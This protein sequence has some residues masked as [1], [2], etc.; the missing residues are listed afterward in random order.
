MIARHANG[1]GLR[2]ALPLALLACAAV[3]GAE[4]LDA[5]EEPQAKPVAPAFKIEMGRSGPVVGIKKTD[6]AK[7]GDLFEVHRGGACIGY[8]EVHDMEG[9]WPRLRCLVGA[10]AKGDGLVP[11]GARIPRVFLA[12]DKPKAP[13][14]AELRALAGPD[15][16]RVSDYTADRFEV[17]RPTDL[18]VGLLHEGA[19]FV[20]GDPVVQPHLNA[21]GAAVVDTRLYVFLKQIKFDDSYLK[22]K[23]ELMI[24]QEGGLTAGL[25]ERDTLPWYGPPVDREVTV[26]LR[27]RK[28]RKIVVRKVKRKVKRYRAR[29]FRRPPL[30]EDP[31]RV[32]A[33]TPDGTHIAVFED[34]DAGRLLVCDFLT[35]SGRA[36]RDPGSKNKL[37]FLTRMLG[38]G[39]RYARYRPE[40]PPRADFYDELTDLREDNRGIV[41]LIGEGDGSGEGTVIRS[42]SLG[43]RDKPLVVIVGCLEGTDWITAT[44]LL[45]LADTLCKNPHRDPKIDRI[46]E[47]LQLRIIPILNVHGYEKDT[48]LNGNGCELNRNFDYAWADYPDKARRGKEPFSEPESFLLKLLVEKRKAIA[49]LELDADPYDAGYRMVRGRPLAEAQCA[50]LRAVLTIANAR[51][52]HRFVVGDSMVQLRLT[53]DKERPSA[54]NWAASKGALAAA[55]KICGDGED[56]LINHDVAIETALAFLEAA[57][58]SR[59]TPPPPTPPPAK[60]PPAK[61]GA[62]P[63]LPRRLP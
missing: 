18:L 21:G 1:A 62:R 55:I 4:G 61:R 22:E 16:F 43:E 30:G 19:P 29:L 53:P 24:V 7:K 31:R 51:L 8:A 52:R 45:Q 36:G 38:T 35:P 27:R 48:A 13:E 57:A 63:T 23:P 9:S 39:P 11:A 40:K 60:A 3:F 49:F 25:A 59:Q 34:P 20:I 6:D 44:A 17:P 33:A 28:G 37:L 12:T 42:I 50:L 32:I 56:S 15:N 5:E 46:N 41:T 26:E 2:A 10:M 14:V 47:R 58:L 54:I